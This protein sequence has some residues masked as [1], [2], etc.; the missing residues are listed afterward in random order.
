MENQQHSIVIYQL[1]P[2]W[3]QLTI[4]KIIQL[5]RNTRQL[6][7]KWKWFNLKENDKLSFV[8]LKKVR[9]VSPF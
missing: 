8:V 7:P 3:K 5:P 6:F 2:K 4:T 1:F 9:R